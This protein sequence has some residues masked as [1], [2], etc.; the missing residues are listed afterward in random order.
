MDSSSKTQTPT[1]KSWLIRTKQ[2]QLLGP[3]SKE[4]LISFVE[5]GALGP[6]D[7]VMS[8][9]GYWFSLKE[10][11]LLDKYVLGDIPQS[12]DPISEAETVLSVSKTKKEGTS[13]LYPNPDPVKME[14]DGG[15]NAANSEGED[16]LVPNEDELAY[17]DMGE[18]EGPASPED[19]DL[20]YP[21][22]G[23]IPSDDGPQTQVLKLDSSLIEKM[24]PAEDRSA[25]VNE[26][27]SEAN[28]SLDSDED[29]GW[30][31]HLP[32]EDD[33]AYPDLD[34]VAPASAPEAAP[35]S[36]TKPETAPETED[37]SKTQAVS[38]A[39]GDSQ[40][41]SAMSQVKELPV[42]KKKSKQSRK[43]KKVIET[44][45]RNDR[46]LFYIL[47]LV[48][49]LTL[50]VFY[51]YRKILNKPFPLIG[52]VVSQAQ[53]QSLVQDPRGLKKKEYLDHGPLQR[54]FI[55]QRF[56]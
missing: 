12:F 25:L 46:Y 40:S 29:T 30:D 37:N 17:P 33:L 41:G 44:P 22:F 27:E 11:D 32:N 7:E 34:D 35:E 10:K 18:I 6:E 2:R 51:Y 50:G 26:V 5:K 24:A 45:R 52:E 56:L 1:T 21:D 43:K 54:S 20:A 39:R 8:G 16:G 28:D 13:S 42:K 53:A 36:E 3:V 15:E 38:G 19:E 4:K 47:A 31:G 14:K 55:E 23:D 49:L 48:V 9:N